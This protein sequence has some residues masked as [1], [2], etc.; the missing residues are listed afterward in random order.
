MYAWAIE[1]TVRKFYIMTLTLMRSNK[2]ELWEDDRKS[3]MTL[4]FS[5]VNTNFFV[6][7][8]TEQLSKK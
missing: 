8:K 3:S 4:Y 7:S 2:G 5:I 1:D 6:I